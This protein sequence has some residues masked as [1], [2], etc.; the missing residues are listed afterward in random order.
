MA[1]A[2]SSQ[3]LEV[4]DVPLK[5]ASQSDQD[6]SEE[7][8]SLEN[9]EL[10]TSEPTTME[11]TTATPTPPPLPKENTMLALPGSGLT[12]DEFI[13][14]FHQ[15]FNCQDYDYPVQCP[16]C[17]C[18]KEFLRE[19]PCCEF[20]ICRTCIR[21][22][23]ATNIDEGRSFMPCP[24]LDCNKGLPRDFIQEYF[25]KKDSEMKAKY[26][27]FRVNQENDPTKKT[28][29]NCCFITERDDLPEYKL[30]PPTPEDYNITCEKCSFQWCFSCYSPWHKDL[31]CKEY[32][33]G[34]ELFRIWT[35]DRPSN[36]QQCPQC[37]VFIQ[38]SEGFCNTIICSQ[39]NTPFCYLCGEKFDNFPN[40]GDH[41]QKLPPNGCPFNMIPE[42]S[43]KGCRYYFAK[44]TS[45]TGYQILFVGLCA[46]IAV[47][48]IVLLSIDGLVKLY[49]KIKE[50]FEMI[51]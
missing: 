43:A 42:I 13:S 2:V 50:L 4:A 17:L 23:I 38:I 6:D 51:E 25:G 26:E 14:G 5:K 9:K 30:K 7:Q 11:T 27:R 33:Q 44:A 39:C 40:I 31:S 19:L 35:D 12:N 48:A 1:V 41:Y 10:D 46:I 36:C 45:L 29:P 49:K 20:E 47:V 16:I 22:I 37:K 32:H 8:W 21:W 28:C 3:T 18:D 34:D 24:N 15:N